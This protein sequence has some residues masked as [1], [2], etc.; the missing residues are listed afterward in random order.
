M[1]Y[2]GDLVV[3]HKLSAERRV[4]WSGARWFFFVRNRL[5]IGRKSGSRWL[6]LSPRYAGYLVRGACNGL[7]LPTLRAWPA[8]VA[9]SARARPFSLSPTARAYLRRTD[10]AHRGS[11]LTRVRTEMLRTLPRPT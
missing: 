2:R 8:A 9:L 5:Y 10:A 7:L 4:A 1:Q 3:R 11:I 6:A